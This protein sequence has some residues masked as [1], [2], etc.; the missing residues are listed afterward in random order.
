MLNCQGHVPHL[1]LNQADSSNRWW[2]MAQTSN[3]VANDPDMFH[4]VETGMTNPNSACIQM[5]MHKSWTSMFEFIWQKLERRGPEGGR[6]DGEGGPICLT[7]ERRLQSETVHNPQSISKIPDRPPKRPLCYMYISIKVA[8]PLWN[9]FVLLNLASGRIYPDEID[10]ICYQGPAAMVSI[11]SL[12]RVYWIA[13][14]AHWIAYWIAC[15]SCFCFYHLSV[16]ISGQAAQAAQPT[17]A[18]SP[19]LQNSTSV[20]RA[21]SSQ[22]CALQ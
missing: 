1:F 22:S 2:S 10:W 19:C 4:L 6:E 9:R 17:T 18:W 11:E 13:Y 16:A 5:N 7:S 21:L 15:L 3:H 20:K 12:T 14:W 8:W